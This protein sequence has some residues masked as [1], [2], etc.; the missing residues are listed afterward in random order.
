MNNSEVKKYYLL[1]KEKKYNKL[2][3]HILFYEN[4]L[5]KKAKAI[6]DRDKK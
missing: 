3:L 1:I 4:I 5:K 2:K 6:E